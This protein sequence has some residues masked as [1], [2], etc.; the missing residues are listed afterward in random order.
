LIYTG[1]YPDALGLPNKTLNDY[2][3]L[4]PYHES[5][6]AIP[7]KYKDVQ[8]KYFVYVYV[9]SYAAL[10]AGREF[11]GFPKK[12]A[13]FTFDETPT[14]VHA[15]TERNGARLIDMTWISADKKFE[16]S[17]AFSGYQLLMKVIPKATGPGAL[18]R[19]V[20]VRPSVFKPFFSLPGG[21]SILLGG[22]TL[23]R[24]YR[25]S[26]TELIGGY[27]EVGDHPFVWAEREDD[28]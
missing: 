3:S 16:V 25:L 21:I 1:Y 4:G 27:Y 20:V 8:G 17:K 15:L 11:S 19:K 6:V 18:I 23:D 2:Y 7:V 26:P 14:R 10:A 5:A 22:S 24:L 9:D 12:D 13:K 28:V